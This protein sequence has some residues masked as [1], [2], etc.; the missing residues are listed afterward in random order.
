VMRA[1][2]PTP[3]QPLGGEGADG[4]VFAG[5]PVL[6]TLGHDAIGRVRAVTSLVGH[7]A[8]SGH[9]ARVSQRGRLE[10]R[11]YDELGQLGIGPD[12]VVRNDDALAELCRVDIFRRIRRLRRERPRSPAGIN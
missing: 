11:A 5:A 9:V 12:L 1:V 4:D 3:H 8:A 6:V 2:H 10:P 7:F